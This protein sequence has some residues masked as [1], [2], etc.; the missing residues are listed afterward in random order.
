VEWDIEI[1]LRW[2]NY[3]WEKDAEFIGNFYFDKC[4]QPFAL[5]IRYTDSSCTHNLV[6]LMISNRILRVHRILYY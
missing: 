4:P 1:L 5:Y 3:G 2:E 6:D